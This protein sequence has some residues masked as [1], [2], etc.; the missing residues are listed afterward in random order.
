MKPHSL[1]GLFV[2]YQLMK[3]D[4]LLGYSKKIIIPKTRK[5]SVWEWWATKTRYPPYKKDWDNL[6]FG[7]ALITPIIQKLL[8]NILK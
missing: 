6:F 1:P 4:S 7:Y 3:Q 8:S 5:S 2:I